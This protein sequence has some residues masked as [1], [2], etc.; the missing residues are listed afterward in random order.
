[1]N[2]LRFLQDQDNSWYLI[3][4]DLVEAFNF[5]MDTVDFRYKDQTAV[6]NDD[7]G[8][9]RLKCPIESYSF[10]V[11]TKEQCSADRFRL[12]RDD[13]GGLYLIP[14]ELVCGF[15]KIV[16]D[17]RDATPIQ[18]T[19]YG[20]VVWSRDDGKALSLY[21][22]LTSKLNDVFGKY[23]LERSIESYSFTEPR[24]EE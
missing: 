17:I 1:M 12:L 3:P 5:D 11:P 18:V 19:Y 16:D 15:E 20:E 13:S 7:F 4:E 6:F 21:D 14:D 2:R 10:V 23:K 24:W 8:K 22:E 9:Y